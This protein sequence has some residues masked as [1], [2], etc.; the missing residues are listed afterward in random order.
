MPPDTDPLSLI[1]AAAPQLNTLATAG[2]Y[3]NSIIFIVLHIII[4]A[5]YSVIYFERKNMKQKRTEFDSRDAGGLPAPL[6]PAPLPVAVVC[7]KLSVGPTCAEQLKSRSRAE[8]SNPSDESIALV[9]H[10]L[11]G[12]KYIYIF[13]T[14]RE[15]LYIR[16]R[17][18]PRTSIYIIQGKYIP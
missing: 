16:T 4:L 17:T 18:R 11:R 8:L 1:P 2:T 15:I 3:T 5:K 6:T 14:F 7:A 12:H 9:C 10:V 13:K